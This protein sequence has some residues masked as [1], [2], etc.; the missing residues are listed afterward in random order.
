MVQAE[1]HKTELAWRPGRTFYW[2]GSTG[3]LT[4]AGAGFRPLL[5]SEAAHAHAWEAGWYRGGAQAFV[6]DGTGAFLFLDGYL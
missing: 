6:P 4:V 2:T 3:E 1:R 5:R